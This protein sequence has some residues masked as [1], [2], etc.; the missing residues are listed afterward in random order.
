MRRRLRENKFFANLSKQKQ[1]HILKKNMLLEPP[2]EI[3]VKA[4][5]DKDEYQGLYSYFSAYTHGN[6]ISF[7]RMIDVDKGQKG[8]SAHVYR[9]LSGAI[10]CINFVSACLTRASDITD[11]IL[12]DSRKRAETLPH[13]IGIKPVWAGMK[14]SE[15]R[16]RIAGA[17]K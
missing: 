9:E 8:I 1:E 6:S 7:M 17:K 2:E 12:V 16:A 11:Q 13:K 3:A 15:L 14:L 5:F 4:G 10:M